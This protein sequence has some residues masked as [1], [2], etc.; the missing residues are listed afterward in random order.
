[1]VNSKTINFSDF[2]CATT[3]NTKSE[4]PST[5]VFYTS[6]QAE[7]IKD[8]TLFIQDLGRHDLTRA[9]DVT[10][11]GLTQDKNDQISALCQ[12][13]AS[14]LPS[15]LNTALSVLTGNIAGIVINGSQSAATYYTIKS[16]RQNFL[17]ASNDIHTLESLKKELD[18]GEDIEE[19]REKLG[20]KLVYT[21]K[22]Q[23]I[24]TQALDGK[25]KEILLNKW[26]GSNAMQKTQSWSKVLGDAIRSGASHTMSIG[27][28]MVDIVFD[29]DTRE[30]AFTNIFN[31]VKTFKKLITTDRKDIH[32]HMERQSLL[33]KLAETRS[34]DVAD[35]LNSDSQT[36]VPEYGVKL[37]KLQGLHEKRLDLRADA[38]QCLEYSKA[39]GA[40][41][42]FAGMGALS[43][44]FSAVTLNIPV[45]TL[46]TAS[47]WA[48]IRPFAQI[49]EPLARYYNEVLKHDV[50]I[51]ELLE[52][53]ALK[54]YT[55]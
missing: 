16:L 39:T 49:G 41:V 23:S 28:D 5:T 4:T 6:N 53:S 38:Q 51:T 18:S 50:E 45:F 34:C 10:L 24:N 52:Q 40:S 25:Q 22:A 7:K 32:S 2:N 15:Y 42:M 20:L 8:Q 33:E 44:A 19:M 54:S 31:G 30:E 21:P 1:M 27:K 13:I 37:Q 46:A 17:R 55:I 26:A 43:M 29:Q 47:T 9:I 35:L 3:P 36:H 14:D 11:T 48:T 12:E